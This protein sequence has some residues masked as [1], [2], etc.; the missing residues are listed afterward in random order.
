VGIKDFAHD[1]RWDCISIDNKVVN[2]K[3]FRKVEDRYVQASKAENIN[4]SPFEILTATAF[5]LFNEAKVD[6][7]VIEVGMGGK[8]DATNILNNQAISVIS[9]IARDHE[10]FLG[11]T[12]EEI[13]KHK[14][15]ILRPNVP[16]IVN[17]MNEWHVHDVI[18][19]YAKEIGAGPRLH[20]DTNE[21]R[22][23]IYSRGDWRKFAEPIRPFQRDNAVLAIVAVKQVAKDLK[24][25]IKP[26]TILDELLKAR[27]SKNL[28]RLQYVKVEPVFGDNKY[29]GKN[30][31][32]DGAHN[33]D[34]AIALAEYVDNNQRTAPRT[35]DSPPKKGLPVT[36][37]LAM[38]EGKDA[39]K[40]LSTLLRPGDN[41]I[42]TSFGPVDG[43]PW[44]KPMD[45]EDL[46]REAER[47]VSGISTLI[48]PNRG[49]IRALCAAKYL[50]RG[51]PIVVTGSL[52]LVGDF[53][54]ELRS[55]GCLQPQT[56][57]LPHSKTKAKRKPFWEDEEF[58]ADW[59]A[60]KRMHR[61]EQ[62]RVNRFLSGQ[63][64]DIV[65]ANGVT[66]TP[67][68]RKRRIQAE[69]AE[70]DREIEQLEVEEHKPSQPS[71]SEQGDTPTFYTNYDNIRK[72]LENGPND[73]TFKYLRIRKQ[74][75]TSGLEL[76]DGDEASPES[77]ARDSGPEDEAKHGVKLSPKIR[78]HFA[79]IKGGNDR[80]LLYRPG[81][82]RK[83]REEA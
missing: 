38:T 33:P 42:T 57:S 17:P 4:A 60:F 34:A 53:Y 51:Q 58:E 72:E 13:A 61:E 80:R 9:K 8:L 29:S 1:F 16:Y 32:V 31:F 27:S 77:E 46:A 40:Y 79:E 75:L 19:T 35:S 66:E 11:N 49:V 28:G 64:T 67:S 24:K 25:D 59:S 44:V 26:D 22:Q 48:M 50:A 65:D 62:E 43:M 82:V 55:V 52:Y 56:M 23:T 63:N 76:K 45:P 7:G 5:T 74:K 39:G 70:L 3:I 69:I 47:S 54:R 73:S 71:S 37:V 81:F 12:L 36:W 68:Q 30:I 2:E 83:R 20:G 21:L 41:V 14:A 6:V 10:G 78:M 15:G 18:D